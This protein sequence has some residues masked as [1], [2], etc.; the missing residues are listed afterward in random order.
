VLRRQQR[1][2]TVS[3]GPETATVPDSKG[4]RDLSV[5]LSRP[6]TDVHVL[7]LAQ[8]LAQD[9]AAGAVADQTAIDA[10]R[11]R[12]VELEQDRVEAERDNDP[13]RLHLIDTE[14]E[15]LLT[16][17]KHA[18]GLSGRPRQ[19]GTTATERVRKAVSARIR[20]AIRHLEPYAPQL[21]AHLD[22]AIITGTWCRYRF[23]GAPT[24][25]IRW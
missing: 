16:Q 3:F 17:L 22:R 4:W 19:L 15:A 5:L 11:H 12:L 9:A 13:E 21:A 8:A 23:Q 24:W 1:A 6:D 25:Q 14:R 10:Y 20:D 7:D 2:W 18:T